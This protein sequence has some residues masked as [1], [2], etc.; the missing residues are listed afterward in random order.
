MP[1]PAP[2][3]P[4]SGQGPSTGDGVR[5]QGQAGRVHTPRDSRV[6]PAAQPTRHMTHGESPGRFLL[7]WPAPATVDLEP[8]RPDGIHRGSP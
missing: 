3:R 6:Q 8:R 5:G 2:Q 4:D 7:C 1:S